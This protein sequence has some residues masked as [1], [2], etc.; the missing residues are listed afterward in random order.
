MD[1]FLKVFSEKE[2]L[3]KIFSKEEVKI[4]NVASYYVRA[5]HFMA[6]TVFLNKRLWTKI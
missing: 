5:K 1:K 6:W 3:Y 2:K 4:S